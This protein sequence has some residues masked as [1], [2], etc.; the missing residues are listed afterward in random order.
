MPPASGTT[1]GTS[2]RSLQAR[3]WARKTTFRLSGVQPRTRLSTPPRGGSGPTSFWKVSW[4]GS[5]PSIGITWTCGVPPY[6]PV[7]AIHL[8][9]GEILGKSSSPSSEVRRRAVPPSAPT[10]QTSPA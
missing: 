9:S 7:K 3:R 8:P 5:P 2:R 4:R 6:S 1:Y 10:V